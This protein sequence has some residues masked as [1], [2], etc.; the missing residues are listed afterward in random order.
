MNYHEALEYMY[1]QLPMFHRVGPA[2]YKPGL[3][4]TYTLLE[5]VGNPHLGL[6]TVHIAGT[7]GKG[8]TSHLIA[9]VLQEA[10]YKTGLCTSPH[11]KDFRERIKINGAMIPKEDVAAF[12]N[13]YKSAWDAIQPSFFEMTIAL[14][15]WYFKKE[16]TDIAVIE[17]GLGGRLDSTNV[18]VPE[19]AVITN[20][21]MDHMNLLGDTI[22]LIAAEKAGIIKQNTPV[23][24]GPMREEAKNVMISFAQKNNATLIDAGLITPEQT[25]E[26]SL[27]GL[28]QN[29]NKRTAFSALKELQ[30]RYPIITD[31]HIKHGF[32]NVVS[33]TSLL[34][35][36]QTLGQSPLM[37][38]DV[39]HNKDGIEFVTQQ[40][41]QIKYN[42]LHFVLGMVSDKDISA[43]LELLPKEALYYFC[44]ANIPRGM[45]ASLLARLASEFGLLGEVHAS[46]NAAF[47]H[48][49]KNASP[50]DLIF[51]G[52]SV[53]TVA[54]VL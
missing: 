34:G 14:C 15:F 10:G 17:T 54:E 22:E 29:E 26:T 37:I 9:S 46:V 20:I 19:V 16:K 44:K 40:L 8:S 3:D 50:D 13:E 5:I 31:D 49:Q 52:G 24:I 33:N 1:A 47:T 27:Q 23:V 21:G 12:V 6:K 38:A 53:F 48:A 28:Y 39:A 7:N 2:A 32:W 36:W 51:V 30:H 43:V 45:D 4:N 18:I 35:R 42:K 11:L 41:Q 25:P